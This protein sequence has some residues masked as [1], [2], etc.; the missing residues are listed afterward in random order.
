MGS[1]LLF[2]QPENPD[3]EESEYV[4]RQLDMTRARLRNTATSLEGIIRHS[5]ASEP[6]QFL[7]E[8]RTLIEDM[9]DIDFL[10]PAHVNDVRAV[11]QRILRLTERMQRWQESVTH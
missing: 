10:A 11:S 8:I 2:R 6:R 7:R 3:E 1:V 4:K 5:E 9:E